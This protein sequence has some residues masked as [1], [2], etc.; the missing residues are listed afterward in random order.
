VFAFHLFQQLINIHKTWNNLLSLR[1]HT[2]VVT[3]VITTVKT[4]KAK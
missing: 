3:Y 2:Y 4:I 1:R